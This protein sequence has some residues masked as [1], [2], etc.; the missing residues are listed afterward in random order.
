MTTEP[1]FG[2][3]GSAALASID[4]FAS[5]GANAFWFHGFDPAAFEGCARHGIAACVEF[6]T[7]R[8][9]F[10]ARPDLVPIGADGRPIRYGRLVQGVCLAKQDFLEETEAALR[11][12][13]RDFTPTGIWLD[14]LTYAGW[15]ETPEPD[16]QESCFCPDCIAD[17]CQAT[18]IDA[19]TPTQIL[20]TAPA[21]WTR[22]KCERIA[23]FARHYAALIRAHHPTCIVGAYMC[24]WTPDEYA[25]EHGGALSRIFAQDYTL[26]AP[27]IEVF[28]PL[29]YAQK[30]GRSPQWGRAFLEQAPAF[31]PAER[32]V[33]L[34]LDAL[35]FP[36]SLLAAADSP[37]PSWGIQLFGGASVFADPDQARIFAQ[38][39]EQ[40]REKLA[41]VG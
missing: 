7:F 41:E 37:R 21:A 29:I 10:A 34:I 32:K 30:S 11:A 39:V 16:L 19:A 3:Y 13:L 26:L 22:Y 18:G 15:F 20:E 12:G 8:A 27:A 36:D 1:L 23:G 17:F 5:Y 28:T 24:P 31:I 2:P 33:Q 6:K 38:A 25:N 4:R 40:I 35:D 9:D 14:Y